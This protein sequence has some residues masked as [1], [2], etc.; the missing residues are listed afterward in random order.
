MINI[1]NSYLIQHKSLSI[2]G[3]GTVYLEKI[4]AISDFTN[5]RIL[6]PS[7]KFRFDK[8]FDAPDKEFFSFLAANSNVQ[9]YEAIKQY[10]EFAY[11]LRNSIRK[12]D[13]F[14]WPQV[15]VL[16]RDQNGEIQF[17]S[18][19]I[20]PEFLNPVPANRVI[21][22]QAKHAILVGEHERT[23]ED[24]AQ[25]LSDEVYVEKESWWTY[26]LILFAVALVLLFFRFYQHGWK[27][28]Q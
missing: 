19:T 12:E 14:I 18:E 26:A 20:Q 23:T 3:L 5:R 15:G 17:R 16:A 9:E 11:E 21:R 25:L 4:P 2:P 7:F 6:P 1:L 27:F 22:Q 28:L 8:Y 10:N 13:Q 24:M